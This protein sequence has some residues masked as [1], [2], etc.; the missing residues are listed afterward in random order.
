MHEHIDF[1]LQ[2]A[3]KVKWQQKPHF[4]YPWHFHSEYE[5]I[6]VIEGTGSS[7]VG[8]SIEGFRAGDM[9]LLGSNLP[10]FWRSDEKYHSKESKENINYIVIQ[11]SNELFS[12]SFFQFVEFQI[13]RDLIKRAE[14]GIRFDESFSVI[15]GKKIIKIAKSKGFKQF[16]LLL[17]LLHDFGKTNRYQLLASES[18]NEQEQNFSNDR[19]TKVLHY[20]NT[21]YQQKVELE[22]VAS[23]ANLHPAAFC[24][25][26]K[27]KT[28]KSLSEYLNDMRLGYACRLILDGNMSISQICFESGFNNLSNFNRTFKKHT[29]YTPTE[30]YKEFNS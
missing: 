30:Y 8:N 7:F 12:D 10:H 17:E 14:R 5:I 4:T 19:M 18:Y 24:R 2:S 11:F 23:I 27:E 25:Y 26:F 13:I 21:S 3:I 16:I 28:G 9:A 1:P 6:Y 29:S 20:I 22:R 15:A